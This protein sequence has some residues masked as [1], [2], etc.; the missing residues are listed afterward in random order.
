[1]SITAS[2]ISEVSTR[3][4]IQVDFQVA[5][6]YRVPYENATLHT[7]HV[8]EE[9][10]AQLISSYEDGVKNWPEWL[11]KDEARNGVVESE[12]L[13][14]TDIADP[15]WSYWDLVCSWSIN[16]TARIYVEQETT[17]D[18]ASPEFAAWVQAVGEQAAADWIG[19]RPLYPLT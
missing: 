8:K 4:R 14:R 17:L 7:S 1:M 3:H 10:W 19:V 13:T 12:H 11:I 6:T 18:P 9:R 5:H 2:V 16:A 15:D